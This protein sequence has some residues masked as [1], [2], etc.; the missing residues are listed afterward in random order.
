M[1]QESIVRSPKG[2]AARNGISLSQVY[3]EMR[4][5]RLKAKKMGKRT[6]ISEQAEQDWLNNLPDAVVDE[7]GRFGFPTAMH[8]EIA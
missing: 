5:G 3:I 8:K 6:L 1:S 7:N 2:F 4:A